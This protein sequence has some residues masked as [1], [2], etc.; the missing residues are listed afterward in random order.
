[1]S[2]NRTSPVFGHSD[3]VRF[4]NAS[5]SLDRWFSDIWELAFWVFET[6]T[7]LIF[8]H[9]LWYDSAK[10][11]CLH[12]RHVRLHVRWGW[13]RRV[14]HPI[15]LDWRRRRGTDGGHRHVPNDPQCFLARVVLSQHLLAFDGL[16]GTLLHH[17][18]LKHKKRKGKLTIDDGLLAWSN[19]YQTRL[20]LVLNRCWHLKMA[21]KA[22]WK[23]FQT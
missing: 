20:E 11:H 14:D 4:P 6:R 18:L 13:R 15:H 17:G 9:L 3:F 21:S 22:V 7:S 2:K 1:M 8:R 16:V 23:C 5:T 10:N 12:V 19:G